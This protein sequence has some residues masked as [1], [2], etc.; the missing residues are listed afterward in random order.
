[1]YDSW[2]E[3][4][5]EEDLKAYQTMFRMRAEERREVNRSSTQPPPPL[6][7]SDPIS[8]HPIGNQVHDLTMRFDAFWDESQEHY[9]LMSKEMD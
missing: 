5:D 4:S 9:V 3:P 1:M 8:P 7:K 2:K 6:E